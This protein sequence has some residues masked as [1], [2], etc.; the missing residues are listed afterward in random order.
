MRALMS[1]SM[2]ATAKILA[3]AL[4]IPGIV[5]PVGSVAVGAIH[6]VVGHVLFTAF[7]LEFLTLE[8]AA[9]TEVFLGGSQKGGC[10][11]A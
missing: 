11:A 4:K 6:A 9:E 7:G 1:I 5:A 8:V 10:R 2:A 3:D